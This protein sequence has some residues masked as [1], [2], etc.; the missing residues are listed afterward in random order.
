MKKKQKTTEL[1]EQGKDI[2][3]EEDQG[4][5]LIP[6]IITY[7][8]KQIAAGNVRVTAG[9]VIRLAQICEE[10]GATEVQVVEVKW[11]DE[12]TTDDAS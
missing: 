8:L 2:A 1:T 4:T 6:E 3:A 9:D 5:R 11:V 12:S 10:Q 7:G